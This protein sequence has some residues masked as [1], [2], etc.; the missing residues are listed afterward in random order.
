[1]ETQ[2][3]ALQMP[4]VTED[5]A[6]KKEVGLLK[7]AYALYALSIFLPFASIAGVIMAYI[8]AGDVA[9][10]HLSSHYSWL[11]RTFWWSALLGF[12]GMITFFFGVGIVVFIATGIWFIYRVIKGFLKLNDGKSVQ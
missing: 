5:A 9:G 11:I 7:I 4:S 12:V 1:M 8:K 6:L 3:I 10:S 2:E